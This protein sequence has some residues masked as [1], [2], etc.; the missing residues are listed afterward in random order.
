MA[1]SK[2][3]RIIAG[4]R[5]SYR[6]LDLEGA[7]TSAC[8]R[9]TFLRASG[10]LFVGDRVTLDEEG[11][12][13]GLKTRQNCLI[14]P[15]IANVDTMFVVAS[16][17]EPD[18]SSYL[19][20]KFLTWL[21]FQNIEASIVFSK[22]DL[23]SKSKLDEVTK[24]RDYYEFLGFSTCLTSRFDPGSALRIKDSIKGRTV[25][26]M[27]QT[28]AGKS[29]LIN[30]IDP[31]LSRLI[32]EYSAALGRGR[33]TTKEVILIPYGDGLIGDTPGFSALD[34]GL[35]AE[36][37]AR[38]FP[39]FSKY[40]GKCYYNDCLHLSEKGCAVLDALDRGELGCESYQ[41]YRR[42]IADAK[43][44]RTRWREKL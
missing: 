17:S 26:F 28:G 29:S 38:S 43:E 11:R 44:E 40:L 1:V 16:V 9:K 8:P 13:A 18:F 39:G 34:L 33:H 30:L 24:W 14:R 15:R 19:L 21:T 4:N 12:I 22:A 32:G 6:L 7:E 5:R 31:A 25:A 3:Y 37:C 2:V 10:Q 35:T 36:E 23:A 27:G 20:D 42:L 41:N